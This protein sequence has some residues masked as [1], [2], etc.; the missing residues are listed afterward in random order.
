MRDRKRLI[1]RV[2]VADSRKG[3]Y[4]DASRLSLMSLRFFNEHQ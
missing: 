2:G 4:R 1:G 3:A